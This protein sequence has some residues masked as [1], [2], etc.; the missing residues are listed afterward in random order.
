MKILLQ[1]LI[2]VLS[3]TGCTVLE[4][5]LLVP[6]VNAEI[7]FNAKLTN[8]EILNTIASSVKKIKIANPNLFIHNDEITYLNVEKGIIET[9]R[10]SDSNVTG[11]RFH[12]EI[13]RDEHLISITIK[14]VDIYYNRIPLDKG[15]QDIKTAIT[16]RLLETI[17]KDKK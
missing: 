6:E 4:K 7:P 8:E 1:L 13:E 2:I 16:R 5:V 11:M 3:L 15:L 9:G 14:G 17:L 10:Y 12:A